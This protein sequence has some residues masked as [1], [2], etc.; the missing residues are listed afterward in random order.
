V[1]RWGALLR[2]QQQHTVLSAALHLQGSQASEAPAVAEQRALLDQRLQE[3]RRQ[4]RGQTKAID[5]LRL[6]L[7]EVEASLAAERLRGTAEES[8][9]LAHGGSKR[10]EAWTVDNSQVRAAKEVEDEAEMENLRN[11]NALRRVELE[12]LRSELEK[13]SQEANGKIDAANDRIRGLRKDRDEAVTEAERLRVETRHLQGR[14]TD[15]NEEMRKLTEQKEALL[16]IVEDL[17]QTC[18]GAGLQPAGRQSMDSI[19]STFRLQ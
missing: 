1:A 10:V 15:L 9:G 13:V 3:G 12:A 16:R 8:G 18:M 17:H 7:Q 6:Q 11:S 5:E 19:K 2:S 4:V 14:Q